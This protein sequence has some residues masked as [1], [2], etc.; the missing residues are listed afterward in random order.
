MAD[1]K[2]GDR[3]VN[4]QHIRKQRQG[5]QELAGQKPGLSDQEVRSVGARKPGTGRPD[6][7]EGVGTVQQQKR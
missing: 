5:D 7:E 6:A 3:E 4:A 2:Q 1:H